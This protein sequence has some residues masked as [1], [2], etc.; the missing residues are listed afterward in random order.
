MTRDLAAL[1]VI[2]SFVGMLIT[3]MPF[4]SL[5]LSTPAIACC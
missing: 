3:W 5:H 4:I 1:V 2:V